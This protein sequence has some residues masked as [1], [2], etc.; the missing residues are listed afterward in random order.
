MFPSLIEP[1]DLGLRN[2][3]IWG[4]WE[5]EEEQDFG[6]AWQPS[7]AISHAHA[8]LSLGVVHIYLGIKVVMHNYFQCL[9]QAF[10]PIFM[11]SWFRDLFLGTITR[12]HVTSSY[13][14]ARW[15]WKRWD[16]EIDWMALQGINLPPTY[17]VAVEPKQT[18]P[19]ECL[20]NSPVSAKVGDC[21]SWENCFERVHLFIGVCIQV[22]LWGRL[23]SL[24]EASGVKVDSIDGLSWSGQGLEGRENN[25]VVY[26]IPACSTDKFVLLRSY[27]ITSLPHLCKA[28]LVCHFQAHVS[29]CQSCSFL[30]L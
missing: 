27:S 1:V 10:S 30:V 26:V 12:M 15:D 20:Q 25:Q 8:P 29:L 2:M 14:F 16:K 28:T 19:Q 23:Q 17:R 9:T 7:N 11:I 5:K 24:L 4:A 21:I 13:T 18:H 3:V 22:Q 6:N